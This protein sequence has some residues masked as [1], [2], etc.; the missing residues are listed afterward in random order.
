MQ[1]IPYEEWYKYSKL[2][3]CTLEWNFGSKIGESSSEHPRV[4]FW[5]KIPKFRSTLVP[6]VLF[7]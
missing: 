5:Q 3:T 2:K 6:L 7:R 1:T 4:N